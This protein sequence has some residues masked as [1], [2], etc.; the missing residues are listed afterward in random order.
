MRYQQIVFLQES[1]ADEF[2]KIKNELGEDAALEYLMQW[3]YGD[4]DDIRDES[5]AGD[6]DFEYGVGDYVV[7]YNPYIYYAGLQK[8]VK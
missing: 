5:S 1:D 8:I 2:F 7:S 6:N 3:D 4:S